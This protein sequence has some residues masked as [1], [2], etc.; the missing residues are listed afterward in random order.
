MNLRPA[1]PPEKRNQRGSVMVET[2]FFAASMF[3][4]LI[5]VL[6]ISF[7]INNAIALDNAAYAGAQYGTTGSNS[8]NTSGMATAATNDAK[9]IPNFSATARNVCTCSVTGTL[10]SLTTCP[11]SCGSGSQIEYV[12]VITKSTYNT[13]LKYPGLPSSFIMSSTATLRV[14]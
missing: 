3:L 12:Q 7:A 10:S 14:Q 1:A 9:G 11:V 6:D 5:G 2:V 4:L 13:L 8:S